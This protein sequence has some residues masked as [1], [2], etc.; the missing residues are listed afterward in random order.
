MLMDTTSIVK[1]NLNKGFEWK[2]SFISYFYKNGKVDTSKPVLFE[3]W[4]LKNS[5]YCRTTEDVTDVSGSA[6]P[7]NAEK[8]QL[9]APITRN[10]MANIFDFMPKD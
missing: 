8:M 1:I 9:G 4:A 6:V 3:L 5:A 2:Y 7:P 10:I